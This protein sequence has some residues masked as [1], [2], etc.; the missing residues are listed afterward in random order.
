MF[1]LLYGRRVGAQLVPNL[2]TNL[3]PNWLGTKIARSSQSLCA[4]LL[5]GST[6]E[7]C[8]N[9]KSTATSRIDTIDLRQ[10]RIILSH[11]EI[12]TCKRDSVTQFNCQPASHGNQVT[13]IAEA[14]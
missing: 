3:V 12:D 9:E 7:V 13:V 6:A 1:L 2:V 14:K 8:S 11:Q 4:F 10:K 5:C